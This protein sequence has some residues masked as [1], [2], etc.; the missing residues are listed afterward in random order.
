MKREKTLEINFVRK[1][2]K[3][4]N[5][6]DGPPQKI[7]IKGEDTHFAFVYEEPTM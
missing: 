1:E 7:W 4:Y 3:L 6:N 2:Q 5:S